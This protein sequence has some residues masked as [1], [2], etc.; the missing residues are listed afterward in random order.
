VTYLWCIVIEYCALSKIFSIVQSG[1][2]EPIV[3]TF[4]NNDNIETIENV[5]FLSVL[6]RA[7]R[8]PSR[9]SHISI[10]YVRAFHDKIQPIFGSWR[11]TLF[12]ETVKINPTRT[13]RSM[14]DPRNG[15]DDTLMISLRCIPEVQ[16]ARICRIVRNLRSCSWSGR[17]VSTPG[18]RVSKFNVWSISTC[19]NFP[20]WVL[21][22]AFHGG[23][24]L[25]CASFGTWNRL[26]RFQACN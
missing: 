1:A 8:D 5:K 23:L 16:V 6:R 17:S 21:E 14:M 12:N 7:N 26:N 15:S 3:R 11:W 9:R 20:C 18:K 25:E 22:F 24:S 10:G 19:T 2:D 13:A 4:F